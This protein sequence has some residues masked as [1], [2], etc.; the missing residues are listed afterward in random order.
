MKTDSLLNNRYRFWYREFD[1]ELVT[2]LAVVWLELI[3][4][5]KLTLIKVKPFMAV[6]LY[7]W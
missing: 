7:V 3:G 1:E 2:V 4:M 5:N 6:K